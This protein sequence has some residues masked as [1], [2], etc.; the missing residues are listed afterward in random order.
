MQNAS[1]LFI[2]PESVK[3]IAAKA[4]ALLTTGEIFEG[5]IGENTASRL[6]SG[7]VGVDTV[8]TVCR[9]FAVNRAAYIQE[10]RELRTEHD[11][12]LILSW[13]LHGAESGKAWAE[14]KLQ[15][16][17][18]S[19]QTD[20]FDDI[21]TLPWLL[22]NGAWRDEFELT[23]VDCARLVEGYMTRTGKEFDVFDVFGVGAPAVSNA[24]LRR[25]SVPGGSPFSTVM[26]ALAIQDE[27]MKVSAH[28]DLAEMN[29]SIG[30]ES[31]DESL[32]PKA[33]RITAQMVSKFIW[34][35][36]VGY[37]ILACDKPELIKDLNK[38]AKIPPAPDK[39]PLTP[40]NYN[41][42]INTYIM[43]FN[44]HGVH[45]TASAGDKKFD[46]I[47]NEVYDLIM[48]AKKGRKLQPAKVKKT[49]GR[50][51]IWLAQ[52]KLAGSFFH[53]LNASWNKGDWQFI[54]DKMPI[55]S[56]VHEPFT[57]FTQENP[58][59][60]HGVKLQQTLSDKGQLKIIS[61]LLTSQGFKSDTEAMF[62]TAKIN[63]TLIGKAATEAGTPLGVYSL[64]DLIG[65]KQII[66]GAFKTT[67]PA[68]VVIL[69]SLSGA[70]SV[71]YDTEL[72]KWFKSGDLHVLQAHHELPGTI[73]A[74]KTLNKSVSPPVVPVP[75]ADT[76]KPEEPK[77]GTVG[78]TP[79]LSELKDYLV[80]RHGSSANYVELPPVI[81]M[82]AEDAKIS[83]SWQQGDEFTLEAVSTVHLIFMTCVREQFGGNDT[84]LVFRRF[85]TPEYQSYSV[86]YIAK[87]IKAGKFKPFGSASIATMLTQ[88]SIPAPADVWIPVTP[89]A[90]PVHVPVSSQ[91]TAFNAPVSY[92]TIIEF[93]DSEFGKDAVGKFAEIDVKSTEA[94]LAAKKVL[95]QLLFKGTVLKTKKDGS[96]FRIL[97]AF[98][99]ENVTCMQTD[100][101][102]NEEEVEVNDTILVLKGDD[103]ELTTIS[104]ETLA[105]FIQAGKLE[106]H[107]EPVA[108]PVTKSV[109]T[110][111]TPVSGGAT[112]GSMALGP[113]KT[114]LLSSF[115]CSSI[116]QFVAVPV[117][118]NKAA[119][120]HGFLIQ[121]LSD[122]KV[123]P[124][125]VKVYTFCGCVSSASGVSLIFKVGGVES[126]D[127]FHSD[128][129]LK[130]INI[131]KFKPWPVLSGTT[132]DTLAMD[133]KLLAALTSK[134]GKLPSELVLCSTDLSG[135]KS[136]AEAASKSIPFGIGSE[137]AIWNVGQQVLVTCVK[138]ID[139]NVFF[140][141]KSGATNYSVYSDNDFA[142]WILQG[143][144]VSAVASSQSSE[145]KLLGN[146]SLPDKLQN[147]FSDT[148][149]SAWK[150]FL[151]VNPSQTV[152]G[153]AATKAGFT[154]RVQKSYIFDGD[155]DEK[156]TLVVCFQ[157]GALPQ[158]TFLGLDGSYSSFS[159][160]YLAGNIN[161]GKFKP[162]TGV[163][164]VPVKEP[165][166]PVW[167][168]GSCLNYE[169]DNYVVIAASNNGPKSYLL[170][171][172]ILKEAG[173][174][175][176]VSISEVLLKDA[177]LKANNP[178]QLMYLNF[179]NYGEYVTSSH[180]DL[181]SGVF[182]DTLDM[183]GVKTWDKIQQAGKSFYVVDI[184][185]NQGEDHVK[186]NGRPVI[187]ET[188]IPFSTDNYAPGAYSRFS[189]EDKGL[190]GHKVTST[191]APSDLKPEK[192]SEDA[193]AEETP[194]EAG[195]Q[196]YCGTSK[197]I[198]FMHENG[199]V[200]ATASESIGFTW[201]LGAVLSYKGN[202]TRT[203]TG[204]AFNGAMPVYIML[205]EIG[206]MNWKTTKKG[207][208]DYGPI[209]S[210]NQGIISELL[211]KPGTAFAGKIFPKLNYPLSSKAKA[212]SI[213]NGNAIFVPA[214]D[215][216]AYYVGTKLHQGKDKDDLW[217]RLVG[218]IDDEGL[219]AVL[220]H[221]ID[222]VSIVD[223]DILMQL[224]GFHYEH[225]NSIDEETGEVTFGKGPGNAPLSLSTE[226][227]QTTLDKS[228]VKLPEG[229]DAPPSV[230]QPAFLEL[231]HGSHVSA[232]IAVI[233]P[234]GSSLNTKD[235]VIGFKGPLVVM[236]HPMNDFGGYTLTFPKGTV[237]KG[238]SLEKTAVREVWEETGLTCKPV[239]FLGDFKGG[240]SV[241]RMYIGY[242]TGGN[243]HVAGK[244]TD[245]VTLKP[246][247]AGDV[248][249]AWVQTLK[250]RDKEIVE[251]VSE[252]ITANGVPS[253]NAVDTSEYDSSPT[254]P[255][256]VMGGPTF[257]ATKSVVVN[258]AS[259]SQVKDV[260]I[261]YDVSDYVKSFMASLA[262][263]WAFMK[264]WPMIQLGF[265]PP[266]AVV[267]FKGVD[268]TVEAYTVRILKIGE[269]NDNLK[270]FYTPF[271]LQSVLSRS[272]V[273]SD[274]AKMVTECVL[275]FMDPHEQSNEEKH[276]EI[277]IPVEFAPV[278]QQDSM[279]KTTVPADTSEE[280]VWNSLYKKSLVPL[281]NEFVDTLKRVV[282]KESNGAKVLSISIAK[283]T[284][285]GPPY[286]SL[287]T[288]SPTMYLSI[289]AEYKGLTLTAMGYVEVHTDDEI[290]WQLQLA[291]TEAEGAAILNGTPKAVSGFTVDHSAT[292][293]GKAAF[294]WF[295]HPSP[296][297][298][299]AIK[300]LYANGGKLDAVGTTFQTFKNKWLKD[301]GVPY[302]SVVSFG[303]VPY[304][305]ALF[306][307]GC[308]SSVEYTCL[309]S[310]LK[311]RMLLAQKK[312][313]LA[314]DTV[315]TKV[316]II[317]PAAK[318]PTIR[319][320][321][322]EPTPVPV[323]IASSTYSD[324]YFIDLLETPDPK[325]FT[326]DS[327]G[328]SG[329]S[330][331]NLLASG[332]DGKKYLYK[333]VAANDK[334][335]LFRPYTDKAAF[336][337]CAMV[338]EGQVPVGILE[339]D[340]KIGSLQPVVAD[341]AP[342]SESDFTTLSDDDKGAILA[343]HVAD[344]LIGDHDGHFGNWLRTPGNKLV[345]ID[346][347]QAF[348]FILQ[349]I[350][351]F[352]NPAWNPPG[353]F[354]V[355]LAKKLLLAWGSSSADIPASAFKQMYFA[356][357]KVQGISDN[358]LESVLEAWGEKTGKDWKKVLNELKVR[359]NDVLAQWTEVI[360]KL[361]KQRGEAFK[362]PVVGV[363]SYKPPMPSAKKK[364]SIAALAPSEAAV[365]TGPEFKIDASE[366]GIKAPENAIIAKAIENKWQGMTIPVD[367]AAIEEQQVMVKEVKF[368]ND[369]SGVA[370]LMHW[371]VTMDAAI[372]A[373][374]ELDK[375]NPVTIATSAVNQG[376]EP[377]NCIPWDIWWP[378]IHKG[379][380]T[381]NQH[382]S[383]TKDGKPTQAT[384]KEVEAILPD[385]KEL[386]AN[387]TAPTGMYKNIP[388]QVVNSMANAYVE[389]CE[390][391]IE[392]NANAMSLIG[393][394]SEQ[395]YQFIYEP[396]V[397]TE[398]IKLKVS[399][400]FSVQFYSHGKQP[401]AQIHGNTVEIK[402]EIA[403]AGLFAA[404]QSQPQY[405]LRL[406]T[407]P[408]AKIHFNK[409]QGCKSQL[410]Q[411]WAIVPG[412]CSPS[413]VATILKIFMEATK[414][415]MTIARPID[416]QIL[417]WSKQAA[418]TQ[419]D[420]TVKPVGDIIT[421]QS[422]HVSALELYKNG[423][424]AAALK[425]LKELVASNLSSIGVA[426]VKKK[427]TVADLDAMIDP[428]EFVGHWTEY[429]DKNGK[430]TKGGF[431]RIHRIGWTRDSLR[432][433]F[434]S[435]SASETVI[436]HSIKGEMG[437]FFAGS[438]DKPGITET[439]GCL[440][441]ISI[442]PFYGV[443]QSIGS[444]GGS[445]TSNG[446][447][448]IVFATMR[449][450]PTFYKKHFYFDISLA[451]RSDVFCIDGSDS[452]GDLKR[453]RSVNPEGWKAGGF[454][455]E[456]GVSSAG[457]S[458]QFN[459]KH[460][461]DL[462]QYLYRAVFSSETEKKRALTAVYKFWGKS[463]KF[464]NGISPEEAFVVGGGA[465][466]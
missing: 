108:T 139:D 155:T 28:R 199:Y 439:N 408:G 120:D 374:A 1:A 184:V 189:I 461:I 159:A 193:L 465:Y 209:T 17:A 307:P 290:N 145:G 347:G 279:V 11:S 317:Q 442:R 5:V 128:Y 16:I 346:K 21:E 110:V 42:V 450:V 24:L 205:T 387:T 304:V 186:D 452:F 298:N 449:R 255:Q 67:K 180:A 84:Y 306:I 268:Y 360:E 212:W 319:E 309:I 246:L 19:G 278:V 380:K 348:K 235:Q 378:V 150:S 127:L 117:K 217:F 371:R 18:A 423:N 335:N 94:A 229:W 250:P 85:G 389:Y 445:D 361:A 201:P 60:S 249:K 123:V 224:W 339:K 43:Y 241:T 349:G 414:L 116:D 239:A 14:S 86:S 163:Q 172:L 73:Y 220:V 135:T 254:G 232:G 277:V 50:M 214:P 310:F 32:F 90:A 81:T 329:G 287:F 284:L 168:I 142:D 291:L 372:A 9:Y 109:D 459:I 370:T 187:Y 31:L 385:L 422:A 147:Y 87:N 88:P 138:D 403:D 104:D 265:P 399:S 134:T 353:N 270:M 436:A 262:W 41:D 39:F 13:L 93:L 178:T 173:K 410:G 369:P 177:E 206:N 71:L 130:L 83:L 396:E 258:T 98:K 427:V 7:V 333:Y 437:D 419:T 75:T 151:I 15:E 100:E 124:D 281:S 376:S 283:A 70:L 352:Y 393:T 183:W 46:G 215:D 338:K 397:E 455:L 457:S 391:I 95:G 340:G 318:Q 210:M 198:H 227:G 443:S 136:A 89:P 137:F 80:Q 267:K 402:S 327:K 462:R 171:P 202:K 321:K 26:R 305:C 62:P 433:F 417:Y 44:K 386:K 92:S 421:K 4:L 343:Q 351:E 97:A 105:P 432:K 373:S 377:I 82:A 20:L 363:V 72:L 288:V 316:Q 261:D 274:S 197:A 115:K 133:D 146:A 3:A 454:H 406:N 166:Y 131:D 114:A 158:F 111:S 207:N 8:S 219:K 252:W 411:C 188:G 244:E 200:P 429:T 420:T 331:A 112:V 322:V 253:A 302:Y 273:L 356:I 34:S 240:S 453:P 203:I 126:Y 12:P 144:V 350:P 65:V 292:S 195:S 221:D 77:L 448:P 446:G 192:G 456:Q 358:Q 312:G 35:P 230:K 164:N 190:F 225:N 251:S 395:F 149:G 152:P 96:L 332:P 362:W 236:V 78:S 61:D 400:L 237:D 263:K 381:I 76:D 248:T 107:S 6:A 458:N 140:G 141:I 66:L 464:A 375:Y 342:L 132:L 364:K 314:V 320:P 238:E 103:N 440:L 463:I 313:P 10:T 156:F 222:T 179:I 170:Y 425:K 194:Q 294:A 162:D 293:T 301:A 390:A 226:T 359:R 404:G 243:P 365:Y 394:K 125:P 297:I 431:N 324:P 345:A 271:N 299:E 357:K 157:N 234:P 160:G 38:K 165:E 27:E 405:V 204:Y 401:S 74:N 257:D 269:V 167:G 334:E 211:P 428:S 102:G 25:V 337:L 466:D 36:F 121:L 231:P 106:L 379:I 383:V 118:V 289:G 435:T 23:P 341:A 223:N 326:L 460:D 245:A 101:D 22:E 91:L 451:L 29:F 63:D 272:I 54:L 53:I 175:R 444:C 407:I 276:L 430:A 296:T 366:V 416:R 57:A 185:F 259:V 256:D 413:I 260:S 176:L 174:Q 438:D 282:K 325:I 68:T 275:D 328:I 285:G 182:K 64:I 2:V 113:L 45:Y 426:G 59:P 216:A 286:G 315:S 233:I 143:D 52:N 181:S 247:F 412:K 56:D 55:D 424:D 40:N 300:T 213:A 169:G 58:L 51:R 122:Y 218:W 266:G 79:T 191:Y 280:D 196:E 382:C 69:R 154:L 311:N 161:K 295:T 129:V 242:L 303:I 308:A 355:H 434:G 33:S 30:S 47:E 330:K 447:D 441:A 228:N 392:M 344:M 415:D 208:V 119:K 368:T 148:Y 336:H 264:A 323:Q 37:C 153:Q 409:A 418:I 367:K 99:I 48:A 398:E 388:M 49:L 354:G 384:I